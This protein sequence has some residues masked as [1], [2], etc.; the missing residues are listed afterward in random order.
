MIKNTKDE[1]NTK[2]HLIIESA[3]LRQRIENLKAEATKRKKAEEALKVSERNGRRKN[4]GTGEV[5]K[6][7]GGHGDQD[8]EGRDEQ[9]GRY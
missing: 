5:S 8:R 7:A 4:I 3:E 2:E 1:D 6:A 9:K